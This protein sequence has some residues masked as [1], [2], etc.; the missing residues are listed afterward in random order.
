[1]KKQSAGLLVYRFRGKE[2]EVFL[3]HPGGPFW[4]NKDNGAWS[5]PKGEF[6]EDEDPLA[7]AIREMEEETGYHAKGN[8]IPLTPVT[9]KSGKRVLAWAVEGDPDPG[10]I[11]SNT[12]ETEWPPRSG[13][14]QAFPEVDRAAWFSPAE[15]KEKINPAQVAF[16]NELLTL[17][18]R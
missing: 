8:F 14:K 11:T 6:S 18:G 12:F 7:A 17:P 3:V 1:M 2:I 13:K 4:K 15:A 9:Q 16:I 5:I 10:H